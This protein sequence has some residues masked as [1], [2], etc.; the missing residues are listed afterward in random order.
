M[1]KSLDDDN[2]I[3]NKEN[4]P[5]I[6]TI[7]KERDNKNNT[8]ENI[9]F[10]NKGKNKIHLNIDNKKQKINKE[11][12]MKSLKKI[13]QNPK[14]NENY[15]DISKSLKNFK[16][17]KN[18][19][20][21]E[22]EKK[23]N[24][25]NN[26]I[27]LENIYDNNLNPIKY[28]N[29]KNKLL[30][31]EK[32]NLFE[33]NNIIFNTS[34]LANNNILNDNDCNKQSDR[35]SLR[36][37]SNININNNSQSDFYNKQNYIDIKKEDNKNVEK[38]INLKFNSKEL[39]RNNIL[40]IDGRNSTK[41]ITSIFKKINSEKSHLSD[42][43]QIY[44]SSGKCLICERNFTVINLCCSKCNIHFFCTKCLKYYCRELIEKGVKRMKCPITKCN[45][46]IYE[47][48]LKSILSDDY[49]QLLYK[50]SSKS[51]MFKSEDIIIEEE[52]ISRNNYEIF[53]KKIKQ[54]SDKNKNIKSYTKNNVIDI[55]SNI[56][57][58]NVRKYKDEYCNNCHEKT[59]FFKTDTIFHKC[60]NCGIKICKYCNKE[61]TSNHLST[62][63]PNHCKVYYRKKE[64]NIIKKNY[65]FICIIQ[66]I[67][68]IA[69]YYI[70]FAFCFLVI[71]KFFKEIIKIKKNENNRFIIIFLGIKEIFC[72]LNTIILFLVIFPI[73]FVWTP[74]F[75]V[76][77]A[78]FDGF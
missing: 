75:P 25:L 57:L 28:N 59:I 68:I 58:Y 48:F 34:E 9:I 38:K 43:N 6:I 33:D 46:D 51:K 18:L 45:Y 32:D 67:Y 16:N 74:F 64:E 21:N 76:I 29:I 55:N 50:T 71:Y 1:N 22:K 24:F 7:T 66:I 8:Q 2:I 36:N 13:I 52:K 49:F 23:Y 26:N 62:N 61:Y 77:I 54:N 12:I 10:I 44:S 78:L 40:N 3:F 30:K 69:I 70:Y 41:L 14:L 56:I 60:L 47:E 73:L 27:K 11:E 53:N 20:E 72:V 42:N 35:L 5:N 19:E 63:N 17:L 37:S 65:C 4:I 39:S 15:S 31:K